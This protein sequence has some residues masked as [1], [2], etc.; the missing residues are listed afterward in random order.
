MAFAGLDVHDVTDVD[1]V[2][3]VLRRHHPEPEVTTR[4][5]SQ[6]CVCIPWCSLG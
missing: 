1:L 4:I 5:W 2:L 6:V 3:F